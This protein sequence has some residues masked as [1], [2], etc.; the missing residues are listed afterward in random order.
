MKHYIKYSI[1]FFIL[2]LLTSF[3]IDWIRHP[4]NIEYIANLIVGLFASVI[5][6]LMMR[7]FVKFE[8]A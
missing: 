8:D 6:V 5:V 4:E 1:L 3:L 2:F 7:F